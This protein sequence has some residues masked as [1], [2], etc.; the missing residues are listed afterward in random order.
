MSAGSRV[1]AERPQQA[2]E[3]VPVVGMNHRGEFLSIQKF[4]GIA[5]QKW[6]RA[7]ADVGERGAAVRLGQPLDDHSRKIRGQGAE[8]R[9]AIAQ[10]GLGLH[11]FGDG[12]LQLA[13]QRGQT[14]VGG[15]RGILRR[16]LGAAQQIAGPNLANEKDDQHRPAQHEPDESGDRP[17]RGPAHA[18]LDE[19]GLHIEQGNS[20]ELVQ[21]GAERG[22]HGAEFVGADLVAWL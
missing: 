8:A 7:V 11:P 18:V 17:R 16:R 19:I 9:L 20:G 1:R 10:R 2:E 4:A 6:A 22:Q 12:A 3:A 5:S 21:L 15:L 13:G 14:A